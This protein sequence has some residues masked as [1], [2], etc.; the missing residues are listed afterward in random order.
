VRGFPLKEGIK[1]RGCPLKI[2]ILPLSAHLVRKRLQI[3]I[4]FP[5]IVPI[6]AD[7]LFGCTNID[8]L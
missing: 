7:D 4:D 8:D 2:V 5:L 1:R 6:T 3:D